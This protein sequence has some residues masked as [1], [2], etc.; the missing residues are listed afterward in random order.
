[1]EMFKLA[2]NQF[3]GIIC[4]S[5]CLYW[6][7]LQ[8]GKFLL[9]YDSSAISFRKFNAEPKD[10]Y[11]EFSICFYG[12]IL[13]ED[14]IRRA[15]NAT[16]EPK[17]LGELYMQMLTGKQ[18]MT[19]E[20]RK[21]NFGDVT[22][23]LE[24]FLQRFTTR[25]YDR[26]KIY[27]FPKLNK[28]NSNIASVPM[29]VKFHTPQQICYTLK[30][31]FVQGLFLSSERLQFNAT[32]ITELFS[33]VMIVPHAKGRFFNNLIQSHAV[34]VHRHDLMPIMLKNNNGSS[35]IIKIKV[36]AAQTLEKR[37]DR[38]EHPCDPDLVDEDIKLIVIQVRKAGCVPPYFRELLH[39]SGV[40]NGESNIQECRSTEQ[41]NT[42]RKG[43]PWRLL[44]F[45]Q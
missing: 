41:F 28:V 9:D 24:D 23:S 16:A 13:R 6:I 20:M 31:E 1:M 33:M 25:S 45:A 8:C 42:V 17:D 29:F 34:V 39:S 36:T 37:L 19:D 11:P 22:I 21:I 32:M 26:K 40:N 3:Y 30:V 12:K 43:F 4:S 27:Q 44:K 35:T 2:S 7:Y 38:A 14:K 10:L 15:L 18:N 5:L